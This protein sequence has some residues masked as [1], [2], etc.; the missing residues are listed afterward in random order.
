M[1]RLETMM[2]LRGRHLQERLDLV[3]HALNVSSTVREAAALLNTNTGCIYRD[4]S[5]YG[6]GSVHDHLGKAL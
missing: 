4:I 5:T 1:K 3:V 2:E 6:L